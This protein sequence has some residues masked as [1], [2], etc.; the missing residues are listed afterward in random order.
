M[1]RELQE[2]LDSGE[3]TGLQLDPV[4]SPTHTEGKLFYNA[5][6]NALSYYNDESEV[7]L[8]IGREYWRRV[9]NDSGATIPNGSVVRFS[10]VE[11][12][13]NVPTVVEAIATGFT[14][15]F[16][17]GVATHDIEDSSYGYVTADGDVNNVDLT[18]FS[19]GDTL[20]L[21]DTVAGG[22]TATRPAIA[23]LIGRVVDNSIN[24]VMLVRVDNS[25]AAPHIIGILNQNAN[26]FDIPAITSY[27]TIDN[28][29]S[30]T[31]GIAT[32]DATAGTISVPY[33]GIYRISITATLTIPALTGIN[34]LYFQ[35]Y[36]E[37][38]A[39]EVI[40]LSSILAPSVTSANYSFSVPIT[41]T[42]GDEYSF[43]MA[44]NQAFAGSTFD[45]LTFDLES[46]KIDL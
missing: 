19:S 12:T 43:R 42:A 27:I 40:T 24:G 17:M 20:F 39:S 9:Y 37:T 21:S 45:F 1:A 4:V 32:V 36:D 8:N 31:A 2:I 3:I 41:I 30:S 22:Y 26:S 44:G 15:A 14:E 34:Y 5:D 33:N 28:Y 16:I 13:E 38:A 18:A 29:T 46:I 11:A 35:L 7:E 23:K 10:G 6:V 25:V